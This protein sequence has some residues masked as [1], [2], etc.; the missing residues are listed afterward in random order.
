MAPLPTARPRR[1]SEERSNLEVPMSRMSEPIVRE[2]PNM[3]AFLC[4]GC[5]VAVGVA[6]DCG[7]VPNR[8]LDT[9]IWFT[10]H[11]VST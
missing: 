7:R 2:E 6:D 9:E 4:L 10:P 3:V 11:L 8:R 1:S 5:C